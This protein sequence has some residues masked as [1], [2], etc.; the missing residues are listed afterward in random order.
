MKVQRPIC[1]TA[2]KR[3]FGSRRN[4]IKEPDLAKPHDRRLAPGNWNQATRTVVRLNEA[5]T[6]S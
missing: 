1:E 2:L 5:G 4:G 3:K 6:E